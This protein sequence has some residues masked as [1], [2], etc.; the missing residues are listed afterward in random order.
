MA[1]YTSTNDSCL[2]PSVYNVHTKT[3]AVL[4]NSSTFSSTTFVHSL[5]LSA[6]NLITIEN[7]QSTVELNRRLKRLNHLKL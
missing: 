2:L 1:A 4:M 6:I 7:V 3:H 5:P